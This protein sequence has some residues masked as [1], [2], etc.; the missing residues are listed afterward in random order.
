MRIEECCLPPFLHF[1]LPWNLLFCSV[2]CIFLV[3]IQ[4]DLGCTSCHMFCDDTHIALLFCYVSQ[5]KVKVVQSVFCTC[6]KLFKLNDIPYFTYVSVSVFGVKHRC[7]VQNCCY[8]FWRFSVQI[9]SLSVTNFYIKKHVYIA[10]QIKI[11]YWI[12][13]LVCKN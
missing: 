11:Q 2:S 12:G 10:H 8:F 9:L 4:N 6:N 1:V 5:W 7:T 3:K 13:Q